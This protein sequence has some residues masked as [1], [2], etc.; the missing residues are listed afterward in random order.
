MDLHVWRYR[1]LFAARTVRF[2]RRG[3]RHRLLLVVVTLR[4]VRTVVGRQQWRR[5]ASGRRRDRFAFF[6]Q[7][8]YLVGFFGQ[9][10]IRS[11]R[12]VPSVRAG[13]KKRET[14]VRKSFLT[15]TK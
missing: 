11:E 1:V 14:R 5:G 15:E 8:D 6:N 4:G 2:G 3:R 13:R 7:F 9:I 12:V 10:A